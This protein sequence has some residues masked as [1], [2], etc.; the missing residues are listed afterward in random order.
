MWLGG[1]QGFHVK[2]RLDGAGERVAMAGLLRGGVAGH[3]E[4]RRRGRGKT[5]ADCV[6]PAT[7]GTHALD[8]VVAR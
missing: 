4:V 6:W 2:Q 1:S 7:G 8:A 5:C 3:E